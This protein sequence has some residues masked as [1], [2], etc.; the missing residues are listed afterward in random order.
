MELS[1]RSFLQGVGLLGTALTGCQP[2]QAPAARTVYTRRVQRLVQGVPGLEGAGVRIVRTI[3]S[4]GLRN[5]DPFLLLDHLHGEDPADYARGFPTHPHR[6]FE[7]VSVML[8]GAIRHRDSRGNAGLITSGGAQ[9]MTA[10]RGILHSEMP[11]QERGLLCGFQLWVNLPAAEKLCVQAYQDL[12]PAR[13][14]EA[15]LSPAGSLVRVV[16][17]E[18]DGLRGP[19]RE[20]PTRPLLFTLALADERPFTCDVPEGH[21]AFAMVHR[22]SV[23]VGEEHAASEVPEGSLAILEAGRRVRLRA[24]GAGARVLFAA[25]RPLREPIA[26]RGPFVMNT[27]AE[28]QRAFEDYRNGTLDQG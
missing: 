21:T 10:G 19:V 27:E 1:R 12:A 18:L 25:G 16:S 6:G 3:G 15:T 22:G 9:W 8:E 2:P 20:R 7:T 5:L 14:A 4:A 17:G 24:R 26:Q 13:L 11:E 28:L 23:W